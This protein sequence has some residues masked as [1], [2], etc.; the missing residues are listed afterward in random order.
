VTL[1]IDIAQEFALKARRADVF[2]ALTTDVG[3]WWGAP[4]L[5][6]RATGLELDPSLGGPFREKW[7]PGG[8]KL[9]ATVTALQPD[10]LLELTGPLHLGVVF[11]IAE[12]RLEDD[13]E[14]T[15]LSFT[16]RGIG[17]ISPDLVEASA[18][19]WV[20]L[21]GNELRTFV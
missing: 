11:G 2:R 18:G 14:G 6:G 12:F 3:S 19:G 5:T 20:E 15:M 16:H 10:R 9:L 7:G 21:L 8:G 1:T 17:E 4:Y 13:A